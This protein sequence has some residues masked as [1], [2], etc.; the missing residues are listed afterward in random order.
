MDLRDNFSHIYASGSLGY[1][2]ISFHTEKPTFIHCTLLPSGFFHT[3][4]L[5]EYLHGYRE[6]IFQGGSVR[7]RDVCSRLLVFYRKYLHRSEGLDHAR[8]MG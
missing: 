2:N 7:D 4:R 6:D 1:A 8:T 3:G 5:P